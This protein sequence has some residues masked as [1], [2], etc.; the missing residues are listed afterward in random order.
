[1]FKMLSKIIKSCPKTSSECW[2]ARQDEF[3][4]LNQ[5]LISKMEWKPW[6]NRYLLYP[7][8]NDPVHDDYVT[9][10]DPNADKYAAWIYD[11]QQNDAMIATI[12]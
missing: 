2:K 3:Q 11:K 8:Q 1:M 6:F 7:S 10:L 9:M 5:E 4:R 12:H